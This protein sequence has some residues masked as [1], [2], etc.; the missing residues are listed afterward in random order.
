[1]HPFLRLRSPRSCGAFFLKRGACFWEAELGE[2][3]GL[4]L[5]G[6][7]LGARD[8]GEDV[9]DLGVSGRVDLGEKEEFVHDFVF[10][11]LLHSSLL[12]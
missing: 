5:V 10:N 9:E 7:G 8:A 1:M 4:V 12:C 3:G 6:E 2:E 11:F